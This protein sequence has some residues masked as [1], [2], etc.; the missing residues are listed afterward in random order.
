MTPDQPKEPKLPV[1]GGRKTFQ[2][3]WAICGFLRTNGRATAM[4]VSTAA[5]FTNTT[6]ELKFA[7]SLMPTIRMAVTPRMARKATKLKDA[8]AC[9]KGAR[10]SGVRPEAL[11]GA[12]LPSYW[13]HCVTG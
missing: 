4:K 6:A 11:T 2:L 5:N 13:G 10:W 7:D 3:S 12:H 8:V 9:G 1:F